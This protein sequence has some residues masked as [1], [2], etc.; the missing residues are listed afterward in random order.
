MPHPSRSARVMLGAAAIAVAL[1]LWLIVIPAGAPGDMIEVVRRRAR[2]GDSAMPSLAA[3]FIAL[4]G[5]VLVFERGGPPITRAV[6]V[7]PLL[8]AAVITAASLAFL[9]VGDG[10]VALMRTVWPDL[11]DF[12]SLR[13]TLPW[14]W[15][16]FVLGGALLVAPLMIASEHL[17]AR[18]WP[19][20]FAYG[21][22]VALA[23]ATFLT[24]PFEDVLIPPQ[25][26][27]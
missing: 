14:A 2:I 3:L 1:L 13:T 12:R 26:D 20:A 7:W 27:L 4:G 17:H 6:P 21:A 16:P 25:G 23:I 15:V 9:H 11:A 22:L 24:L 10:L 8:F 19:A 5:L 18:R